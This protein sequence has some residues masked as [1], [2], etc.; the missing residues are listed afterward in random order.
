[1]DKWSLT[2]FYNHYG[3]KL[4]TNLGDV[5]I[6]DF[7]KPQDFDQTVL[8]NQPIAQNETYDFVTCELEVSKSNHL[9]QN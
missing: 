3:V 5:F 6:A 9:P 8:F 4:P 7:R 1:M 2:V